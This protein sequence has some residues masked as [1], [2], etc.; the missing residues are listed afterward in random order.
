[1]VLVVVVVGDAVVVLVVVVVVGV[2]QA[3]SCVMFPAPPVWLTEPVCAQIKIAVVTVSEFGVP[4]HSIHSTSIDGAP[5][6]L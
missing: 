1:V 4:S 5:S 3:P 2:E 6:I